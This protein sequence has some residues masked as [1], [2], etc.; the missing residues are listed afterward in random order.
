MGATASQSTYAR[1]TAT[2][3]T[4][5]RQRERSPLAG[6]SLSQQAVSGRQMRMGGAGP[7]PPPSSRYG[8]SSRTPG[9]VVA[10]AKR[11]PGVQ[12]GSTLGVAGAK[13][14]PGVQSGSTLG[15]AGAKRSPGVQSGSTM[16]VAGAKRS[17]NQARLPSSSEAT[18]NSKRAAEGSTS[19]SNLRYRYYVI[20]CCGSGSVRIR[21]FV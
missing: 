12:S 19:S 21:N 4:S 5:S 20:Q 15:V 2:Q 9:P 18:S 3:S 17:P 16:G 14:S 13:R 8:I 1:P 6:H 11:S 10:G 7:L